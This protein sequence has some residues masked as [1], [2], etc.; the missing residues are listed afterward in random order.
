MRA[1]QWII[2]AVWFACDIATVQFYR[3]KFGL[4]RIMLA[5]V[6]IGIPVVLIFSKWP[7]TKAEKK[8]PP[9]SLDN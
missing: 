1:R 4:N 7:K 3:F 2:L 6:I 9:A 8:M 5:Y